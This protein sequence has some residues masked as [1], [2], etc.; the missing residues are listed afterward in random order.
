MENFVAFSLIELMVVIAIVALLSAVA[1]PAYKNY[2]ISANL[3]KSARAMEAIAAKAI[4]FQQ[5]NGRFGNAYDLGYTSTVGS[6]DVSASVAPNIMPNYATGGLFQI[7]EGSSEAGL[8][9]NCG[10]IGGLNTQI[11]AAA[12]GFPSNYTVWMDCDY[13]NYNNVIRTY[14]SYFVQDGAGNYSTNNYIP[15]W[16]IYNSFIVAWS[17]LSKTGSAAELAM[18]GYTTPQCYN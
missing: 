13:W 6:W 7:V 17:N 16:G 2:V 18:P 3:A 12:V 14:C 10:A 1:I 4:L 8:T 15:G 5:T 11:N 9:A